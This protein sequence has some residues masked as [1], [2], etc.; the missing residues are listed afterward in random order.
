[1]DFLGNQSRLPGLDDK[2]LTPLSSDI[3]FS[4]PIAGITSDHGR[5]KPVE[6]IIGVILNKVK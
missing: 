6:A 5:L 4:V 2:W 1:M 3:F